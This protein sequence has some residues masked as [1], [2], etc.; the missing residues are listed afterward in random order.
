MVCDIK[1]FVWKTFCGVGGIGT[2]WKV[3]CRM[4]WHREFLGLT[5]VEWIVVG[6]V[7]FVLAF[8]V[9]SDLQ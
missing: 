5:L 1:V 7:T 6:V 9:V 8:V 4:D 3:R 2:T